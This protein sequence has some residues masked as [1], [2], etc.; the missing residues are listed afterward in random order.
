M[1]KSKPTD[2]EVAGAEVVETAAG[3]AVAETSSVAEAVTVAKQFKFDVLAGIHYVGEVPYGPG[4]VV[5]SDDDLVVIYG[6]GK[7]RRVE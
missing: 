5:E 7:F 6:I 1:A 2:I 3:A 4:T